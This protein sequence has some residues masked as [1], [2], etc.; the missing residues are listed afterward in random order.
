VVGLAKETLNKVTPS[1]AL[2]EYVRLSHLIQGFPKSGRGAT[3]PLVCLGLEYV[4]GTVSSI[5]HYLEVP[6][7]EFYG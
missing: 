5:P 2:D 3:R 7:V 4:R 6:Y 1:C